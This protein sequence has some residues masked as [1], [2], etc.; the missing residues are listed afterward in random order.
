[1]QRSS[2]EEW[3]GRALLQPDVTPASVE[4]RE[5]R[6][7]LGTYART[8]FHPTSGDGAKLAD[9]SGRVYWDLLAGIAVNALGHG[10][11][12]IR[13]ALIEAADAPLHLSNLYYHP[14]QGLLAQRLV[15]ISGLQRA[16]FCNSG[17]EANEAA[18]KF[19]KLARPGRNRIVALEE[20]FHGRSLGSLAVTGHEPYRTPFEPFG[21]DVTFVPPNDSVAMEAAIGDDTLAVFL[22]PVMGEAGVVP[23]DGEF[24]RT[25]ARCAALEG[26]LLVCDE[27]QSGLGRTGEW[28]AFQS[29]G[30]DPDIVTLAKPLGGGLPLGAVL[31]S[32]EVASFV[33][34]G[35][36]GTTFG[37]NPVACRLGLAVIDTIVSEGLV[38]RSRA[39]G[40]AFEQDLRAL[41]AR[42]PGIVDVRGRGL[43]WGIELS[44]DAAPVAKELFEQGFLVGV[45]RGR[46]IRIAPPLVVPGE[47]LSSFVRA[48]ESILTAAA[49]SPVRERL[50]A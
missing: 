29:S 20:G 19:A 12:A 35:H 43:M 8:S 10:H 11:P 3:E 9:A 18:I 24:I 47:A 36:H 28:F 2:S 42:T 4:A 37:G 1:M 26:A 48:L 46:T 15:S 21:F 30:I 25:A 50:S 16:F 45:A 49:D 13:R 31:V 6:Y 38:E 14:Y 44:G 32:S 33:K 27:V 17:T 41:A 22:E 40:L 7:M 23:L 34:P 39:L 5:S